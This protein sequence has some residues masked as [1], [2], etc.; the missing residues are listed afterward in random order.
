VVNQSR[1]G[2][3][4]GSH[5]ST[6]DSHEDNHLHD[7]EHIPWATACAYVHPR[8]PSAPET[9]TMTVWNGT[10]G[11]P[12]DPLA[13][14]VREYH[15]SSFRLLPETTRLRPCHCSQPI[16]MDGDSKHLAPFLEL[17][18][19]KYVTPYVAHGERGTTC[20]LGYFRHQVR[21]PPQRLIS[22]ASH[23]RRGQ[24]YVC[25]PLCRSQW[26]LFSSP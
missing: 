12:M 6:P 10:R 4:N 18:R 1:V 16:R 7:G 9:T 3:D 19:M 2:N 5:G 13:S 26:T 17:A 20:P 24:W 15:L 22:L 8:N 11:L 23:K 14:S 21:L 25:V